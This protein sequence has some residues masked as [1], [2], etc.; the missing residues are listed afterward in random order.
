MSFDE[1][2]KNEL[3]SEAEIIDEILNDKQG[4]VELTLGT[5]NNGLGK[6]MA[7]ITVIIFIVTGLMIWTGYQFFNAIDLDE[8]VFWGVWFII[9]V[10][11]QIALKQWTWMEINRTSLLREVKRVEIEVAKLAATR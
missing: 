6:W 4:M 11:A 9:T 2:V 1:R 7:L 8:R 5:F 3:E 10:S